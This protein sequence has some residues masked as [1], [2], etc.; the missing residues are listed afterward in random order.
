MQ[1]PQEA[2][3]LSTDPRTIALAITG[4]SGAPYALRLLECL[5][6]ADCRVWLMV[7][8]PGQIVLSMETDL[9]LSGRPAEMARQLAERFGARPGRLEV[10]GAQQW[11]APVASGSSAPDAMVVC[12]CTTGTLAAV[13]T[14]VSRSLLE[15]AADVMIKEGRRLV[16]VVRE[17]PLSAIHLEHM[18]GLA[19]LGVVIL[20]ANPGFY[21]GVERVQDLVDF[22]VARILDQLDI[23]NDLVSRWGAAG[24]EP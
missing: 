16:L 15:R 18:L 6:Q 17:T 11:T 3:P 23:P 4:A 12:P 13:A 24:T 7:S 14:G 1:D 19:R 20:P 10:F 22:V 5:L 2:E 21:H 9:N 8:Q